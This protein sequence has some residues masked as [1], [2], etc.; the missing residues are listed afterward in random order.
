MEQLLLHE[1]PFG[2][3]LAGDRNTFR[4]RGGTESKAQLGSEKKRAV[5]R[6]GGTGT[7]FQVL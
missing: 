5:D 4:P 2:A 3:V 6:F 1:P 7:N